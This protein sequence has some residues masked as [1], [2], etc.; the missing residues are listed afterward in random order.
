MTKSNK[1]KFY[2]VLGNHDYDNL[3]LTNNS[4]SQVDMVFIHKK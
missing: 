3:D 2:M 1:V 4:Q